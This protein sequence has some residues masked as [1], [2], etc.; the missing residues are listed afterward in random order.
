MNYWGF[1]SLVTINY[2]ESL[3]ALKKILIFVSV[4]VQV[5]VH[6]HVLTHA[7]VHGT[8]A[9]A[10]AQPAGVSAFFPPGSLGLNN[11]CLVGLYWLSHLTSPL[12]LLLLVTYPSKDYVL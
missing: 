10:R 3:L 4:C 9:E 11:V 1:S 6:A 12:L 7:R 8:C 5:C 2:K